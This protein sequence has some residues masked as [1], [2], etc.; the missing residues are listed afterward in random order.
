VME[1]GETKVRRAVVTGGGVVSPIG[2]TIEEFWVNLTG[3]TSGIGVI[4]SFD[5]SIL[6]IHIAGEVKG[7]EPRD[8][9]DQKQS[10]R[11]DRFAQFAV[12]VARLAVEDAALQIESEDSTRIGIVMNTGSGGVNQVA[13]E[14]HVLRERGAARVSPFFVPL[15]SPNMASAQPALQLSIR[16]PVITSVAACAAGSMAMF[17][18]LRLIRHG[19]AD[20]VIAGGTES[21][22]NPL[23]FAGF[24]NMRALS[25][26]NGDPTRASRPFDRDRDGFVLG[27]GAAA[28][29]V[30][31]AEHAQRRGAR[32]L[33]EL[34]GGAIT[35]DAYHITAPDPDGAGAA[36]AMQR[37]LADAGLA[38]GEIDY[39]AAHGTGTSLN[40]AA[41]TRAIKAVFGPH[42]SQLAISA[43]KSMIGHLCGA[44]GA[45]SS[46]VCALVLS[47]G[48]IPPTINLETPD[49]DCDLD[50]VPCVKREAYVQ[51]ALANGFGF[52]GQ[53]AVAAFRAVKS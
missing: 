52:G 16:G 22:I 13:S 6:D 43:N 23:A 32:V 11:M 28:L 21:C 15:M 24:D 7:F 18:A 41:E 19:D 38:P 50:Y 25:R 30:E 40:D 31:S 33:C 10:R 35:A 26:R 8:Y 51:A 4:R 36:L 49:E 53:N 3:G 48:L 20:V 44:A 9:M 47:R 45:V 1:H 34:A 17:E 42:A 46:L 27:E 39:I 5:H 14:E 37:A 2:L 12:A 29:V